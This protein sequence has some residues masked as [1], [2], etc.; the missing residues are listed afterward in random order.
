MAT[1]I[2]SDCL[3][4]LSQNPSPYQQLLQKIRDGLFAAI[5]EPPVPSGR[6][7]CFQSKTWC[8]QVVQLRKRNHELERRVACLEA[9]KREQ[10]IAA[11][12]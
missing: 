6:E 7:M 12:N 10:K 5:Y 4:V 2:Y 3:N 8:S 1:A 9:E 11:L